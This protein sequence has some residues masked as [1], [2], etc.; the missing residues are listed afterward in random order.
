[1][2]II[3]I[4]FHD[5]V[6][7]DMETREGLQLGAGGAE[8]SVQFYYAPEPMLSLYHTVVTDSSP[9]LSH[10]SCHQVP[11]LDSEILI[12]SWSKVGQKFFPF[13]WH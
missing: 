2:N 12:L 6:D 1:M 13:K 3:Y 8:I 11:L 7:S 10:P 4:V 5:F 9:W